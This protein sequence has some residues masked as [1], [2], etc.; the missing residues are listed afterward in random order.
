[1]AYLSDI[2]IVK[3]R[4]MELGSKDMIVAGGLQQVMRVTNICK[5]LKIVVSI[6]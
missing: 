5:W 6:S 2:C 4:K 3:S 1:M